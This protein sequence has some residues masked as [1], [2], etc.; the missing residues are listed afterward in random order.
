MSQT[1]YHDKNCDLEILFQ[2]IETWFTQRNYKV[3][4]NRSENSWLL[5]AAQNEAWR[6]AAGATR[7]FN[8][9]INGAPNDFSI[10]LSTGAWANN[11]AAGG[12]AAVLTGGATLLIS[13]VTVGWSKK[14]EAD[15]SQ[16][17]EQRIQY[18]VKA[19]G[20]HEQ[21]IANS[22]QVLHEKLRQLREAYDNGFISEAAY[23]AKKLGLESQTAAQAELATAQAQMNKLQELFDNGILSPEE[24]EAKKGEVERGYHLERESETAKLGSALAAGI[25]TQQEYDAKKA[26][27]DRQLAHQARVKQL[28]DARTAGILTEAEFQAKKAALPPV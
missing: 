23:N 1:N 14:I 9:Q 6:V 3:Q 22:Q 24:F 16:Y 18:G 5:Q 26:E 17:I 11:L 2:E 21:Q 15:I 10:E 19:K 13:G 7:A 4:T 28:E 20:S 25:L 27:I 12:I 8:V